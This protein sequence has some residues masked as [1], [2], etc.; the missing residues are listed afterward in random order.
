MTSKKITDD[1]KTA[2]EE[3]MRG[4][5]PLKASDKLAPPTKKN[6]PKPPKHV[7]EHTD[8]PKLQIHVSRQTVSA[9]SHL[10]YFKTGTNVKTINKMKKGDHPIDFK[11]D[12]HG[13][14]VDQAHD[15][16]LRTLKEAKAHELRYLLIVHG[17]GRDH[18]PVL[19]NQINNWLL[20]LPNIIGFCSTAPRYGGTGAVIVL[21]SR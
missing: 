18:Y 11:L 5:T 9:D 8:T 6:L 2:F 17:K 7:T 14:T 3:A 4:V 1:D 19:K 12:C 16:L 21:L 10:H 20:Q 13:M 15:A